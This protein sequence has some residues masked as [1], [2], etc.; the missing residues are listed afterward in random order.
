MRWSVCIP[1]L[2]ETVWRE[3]DESATVTDDADAAEQ[4]ARDLVARDPAM[5]ATFEGEGAVALVRDR[6]FG[7]RTSTLRIA[8]EM[9]PF[10]SSRRLT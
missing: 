6:A 10:F 3:V 7:T 9:I 5:F 8:A 4:C 2:D 1:D